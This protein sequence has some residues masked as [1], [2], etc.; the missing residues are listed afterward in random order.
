MLNNFFL[1]HYCR[2]KISY[3]LS[4]ESFWTMLLTFTAKATSILWVGHRVDFQNIILSWQK[5]VKRSSLSC[6]SFSKKVFLTLTPDGRVAEPWPRVFNQGKPGV[7]VEGDWPSVAAVHVEPG[8][9]DVGR[10]LVLS[11]LRPQPVVKVVTF[12]RNWR[13]VYRNQSSSPWQ[14]LFSQP[15]MIF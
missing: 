9:G 2:N 8:P 5:F 3:C 1:R 7:V 4:K 13:G 11:V 10:V 14:T 6:C 15:V 12:F